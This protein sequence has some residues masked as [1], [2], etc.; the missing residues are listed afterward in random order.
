MSIHVASLVKSRSLGMG[1]TVKT[2]AIL[3]ADFASDDGG[4]V[5]ASKATM[6]A[7]LELSKRAI[8][9][10]VKRLVCAGILVRIGER[11]HQNGHT[12]EY[13]FDLDAVASFP[14]LEHWRKRTERLS[15]ILHLVDPC[16]TCTPAPDAP[17]APRAGVNGDTHAPDAGVPLHQMHPNHYRTVNGGGDGD[18][19]EN[20]QATEAEP[21][22]DVG[23]DDG[24][25]SGAEEIETQTFRE[26]ILEAIGLDYSGL[27][28]HGGQMVGTR[29]DM[30][31]VERWR[32]SGLDEDAI[33][34]VVREVVA[35]SGKTPSTLRYFTPA[36]ER[37][38]SAMAQGPIKPNY[39]TS[40]QTGQ[41]NG[42]PRRNSLLAAADAVA[43][44]YALEPAPRV[45]R[46]QGSGAAVALLLPA[47][48]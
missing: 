13:S 8:D 39:S 41:R 38:V 47:R 5:W 14:V 7:E 30:V 43:R 28:G 10:A 31:E 19:S 44:R 46:I 22:L 1:S 25:G 4:G 24:Q 16:T 15:R 35:K 18:A 37:L 48:R 20:D 45:D 12:V 27:T 23:G 34:D 17:P 36:M 26:K 11:P 2:V 40:Q 33:L 3:M 32:K 21:D 9:G 42:P 6:A 29:A